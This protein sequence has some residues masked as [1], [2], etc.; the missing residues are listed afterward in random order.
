[1]ETMTGETSTDPKTGEK[2]A[3]TI[4]ERKNYGSHLTAIISREAIEPQTDTGMRPKAK[5]TTTQTIIDLETTERHCSICSDPLEKGWR[6]SLL[7][8]V[9]PSLPLLVPQANAQSQGL[10]RGM[11]PLSHDPAVQLRR[12]P[13]LSLRRRQR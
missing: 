8:Y 6:Y 2:V 10:L 4:V 11:L 5:K 1:M 7:G 12:M 9:R 3:R 13:H